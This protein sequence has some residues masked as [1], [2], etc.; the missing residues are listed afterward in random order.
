MV[1]RIGSGVPLWNLLQSESFGSSEAYATVE[2]AAAAEVEEAVVELSEGGKWPGVMTA[3]AAEASVAS[4][5][6]GGTANNIGRII[7]LIGSLAGYTSLLERCRLLNILLP[8]VTNDSLYT[9]Q[10][11]FYLL[12]NNSRSK[13]TTR[14]SLNT[15][16]TL[17]R[18]VN[19][20]SPGSNLTSPGA[21]LLANLSR[22]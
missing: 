8:I 14:I 12:P 13:A 18:K 1:P 20:P 7:E 17:Q 2:V 9:Q 16:T 6:S 3:G 15:D 10:Q 21:N 19:L 11:M 22:T 5:M 4:A